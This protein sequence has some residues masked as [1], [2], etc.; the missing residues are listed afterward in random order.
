LLDVA[1]HTRGLP[2][3]G[4]DPAELS[5]G[6]SETAAVSMARALAAAGARV[7]LYCNTPSPGRRDGV[8]YAAAEEID[9][10]LAATPC[11]VLLSCRHHDVLDR[12]LA[13]RAVGLW[14]H[15]MPWPEM[16][17]RHVHA[18]SRMD[19]SL[20]LSRFQ[21]EEYERAVPG[22]GAAALQT[23]NGVDFDALERALAAGSAESPC[24]TF[25]YASRPERGLDLLLRRIWPRLRARLPQARLLVSS[26]DV[27]AM[28]LSPDLLELYGFCRDLAARGPGVEE[29]GSL[30]RAAFWRRLAG[31]TALLY[32]ATFPEISCMVAL[33]AQA[34]GVPV[35]TSDAFA[36]SE[37]VATAETRIGA[38]IGGDAYVERFVEVACRLAED[39]AFRAAAAAAGRRHVAPASHSWRAI[40]ERWSER[41]R[42]TL[43]G[44]GER[45]RPRVSALLLARDEEEHI[46]A[47]VAS[48]EGLADEVIVGDTGST[49]RTPEVLG[50]LGFSQGEGSAAAAPARRVVRLAFED[51]AQARN[52][53][54]GHATGD[55]LY[56]QDADEVLAGAAE[57][58]R[59]ID[60][61]VFY[62]A[63]VVEQRHHAPDAAIGST[64]PVRCY[65]PVTA[66]GPLVWIGAVHERVEHAPDRQPRRRVEVPGVRLDHHGYARQEVRLAKAAGRNRELLLRDRRELPERKMGYVLGMRECLNVARF[67][68]LER[69]ELS[70]EGYR[71]LNLGWEIW[72]RRV[73]RFPPD[74]RTM[75]YRFSREILALLAERRLPLAA[76]GRIPI[77]IDIS[78]GAQYGTLEQRPEAI[79]R[80]RVHYATVDELREE[81]DRRLADLERRL[82]RPV[83]RPPELLPEG[84]GAGRALRPELFGLDGDGPADPD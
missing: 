49:D 24:P 39:A 34:A 41:F 35:V 77:E 32:P 48:L 84:D 73:A 65:R 53:L 10:R 81:F 68:L 11:D 62:D 9:S 29:L 33:E 61:N 38:P 6:G 3:T 64:W 71:A 36:L 15:D 5:L 13:A 60:L 69:G 28:D 59:F 78:F 1:I 8:D 56:W 83:E 4:E 42:A 74:L 23:T 58:R 70:R 14:H 55:W 52:A 19:L 75:G 54:A 26:Y 51:F 57:L 31:A 37:T 17:R 45:S 76:T 40:A 72:R 67:E 46:A 30:T 80:E 63:L 27:G 18:L 43:A 25:V 44:A 7:T 66:D 20:F 16:A 50:S 2:I 47:A 22:I 79:P 82:G 12:P 21:R